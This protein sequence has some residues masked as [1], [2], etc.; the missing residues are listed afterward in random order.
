M[1]DRIKSKHDKI[2]SFNVDW[3]DQGTSDVKNRDIQSIA[4]AYL[5]DVA[6]KECNYTHFLYVDIDEY[7]FPADFDTKIY[8]YIEDLNSFDI[9]SFNWLMQYGDKEPFI[10]PFDNLVCEP[11]RQLKSLIR[12]GVT[13]NISKYRCHLPI[14]NLKKSQYKHIDANGDV[15]IEGDKPQVSRNIPS[16]ESKSFILHR[17]YRS[18]HEYVDLLSR[19]NPETNIPIK[20]NRPLGFKVGGSMHLSIN[21]FLMNKYLIRLDEFIQSC[22]LRELLKISKKMVIKKG[23]ALLDIDSKVILANAKTY[24]IALSG[25]YMKSKLDKVIH[26]SKA[27]PLDLSEVEL[28]TDV[29]KFVKL[30]DGSGID[31]KI[32]QRISSS[33]LLAV[34]DSN[35]LPFLRCAIFYESK[36][37]YSMAIK[38]I[39]LALAIRPKG[40]ILLDRKQSLT[41]Q[42]DATRNGKKVEIMASG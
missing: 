37:D 27:F 4:Y 24:A 28:T 35:V 19:E 12:S 34:Q 15:F 13:N 1:I 11:R 29:D 3:I 6:K 5:T 23:N 7:W 17:A 25:T 31:L 26:S 41:N 14:L 10:P 22:E 20:N 40:A 16:G 36:Q 8:D 42:L 18:E 32:Y 21:D 9:A 30:F 38:Y 33:K 39:D 2:F